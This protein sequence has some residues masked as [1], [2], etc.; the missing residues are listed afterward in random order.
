MASVFTQIVNETITI[1]HEAEIEISKLETQVVNAVPAA[2]TA[3]AT[4]A[5]DV[6]Q[7]ASDLL[8]AAGTILGDGAKPFALTL[9]SSADAALAA[10][11]HG[12]SA[13]LNPLLNNVI[14][15]L[16]ETGAAALKAWALSTKG[17]LSGVQ[18]VH[19]PT[20][21]AAP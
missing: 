5:Q 1:F 21:P 18:V 4:L 19:A 20:P 13:L 14:D 11:T 16:V 15:L 10:L 2:A 12:E 8:G 3:T 6:R 9:E 17:R 7:G